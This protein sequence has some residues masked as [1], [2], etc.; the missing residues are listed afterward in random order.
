MARAHAFILALFAVVMFGVAC[1]KNEQQTAA[2]AGKT[3]V[4]K[5]AITDM[6]TPNCPVLVKTAVGQMQGVKNVEA[7]LE[8]KSATVEYYEGQTTPEAIL[9]VITDQVGFK[10]VIAGS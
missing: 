4:A 2:P 5:F 6:V 3:A 8:S 7:D 1:A 9:K 10:A